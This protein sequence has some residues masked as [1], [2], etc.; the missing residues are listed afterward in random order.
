MVVLTALLFFL[1]VWVSVGVW[2]TRYPAM[3]VEWLFPRILNIWR[4]VFGLPKRPQMPEPVDLNVQTDP[5]RPPEWASRREIWLLGLLSM[6]VGIGATVAFPYICVRIV[7]WLASAFYHG[8]EDAP[9]WAM[10]L[11]VILL[12]AYAFLV[13]ICFGA[14]MRRF[15]Q[16]PGMM[17]PNFGYVRPV[18]T[19]RIVLSEVG[20]SLRCAA[21][22]AGVFGLAF[23]RASSKLRK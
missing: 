17:S 7:I 4:V 9:V 21:N 8:L 13:F 11:I 20:I 10:P 19:L 3:M 18:D 5:R 15:R 2:G 22:V 12:F 23:S 6:W 1:P 16:L 14:I